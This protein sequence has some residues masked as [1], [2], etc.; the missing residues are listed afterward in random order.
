[1][2]DSK[3]SKV[4]IGFG[5]GI[6]RSLDDG[7]GMEPLVRLDTASDKPKPTDEQIR[8]ISLELVSGQDV[9]ALASVA[10]SWSEFAVS[11]AELES[12]RVPVLATIAE[13]DWLNCTF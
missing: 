1:M 12:N 2:E 7:R 9:K 3:P 4:L 5:R 6:A 8:K 11:N 13:R 10:R